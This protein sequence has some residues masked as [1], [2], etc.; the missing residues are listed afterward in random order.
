[1]TKITVK[2]EGMKCPMCEAHT[3]ECVKSNFKVKSVE[4]SHKDMETVIIAEN[5]IDHAE[6]QST[7]EEK[8]GYKVL[9]IFDEEMTKEKKCFLASLFGKK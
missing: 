2:I 7:I 5:P 6:L 4:S 9:E 8:T 3:N 1:M